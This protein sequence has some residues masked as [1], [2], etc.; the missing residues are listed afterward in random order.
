MV[1]KAGAFSSANQNFSKLSEN[2]KSVARKVFG[3]D[4]DE[5]VVD[6]TVSNF[7]DAAMLYCHALYS[8]LTD[9]PNDSLEDKGSEI[10][11]R[12]G[13]ITIDGINGPIIMNENQDRLGKLWLLLT[14]LH[15]KD[16]V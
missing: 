8:I 1:V 3:Y 6:S 11:E 14:H 13:G 12:M 9:S 10:F 4:F 16:N 7:F 2:I 15:N 5:G